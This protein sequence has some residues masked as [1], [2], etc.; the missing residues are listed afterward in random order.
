MS[1]YG[2]G[3]VESDD[4]MVVATHSDICDVGGSAWHDAVVCGGNMR[5]GADKEGSTSVDEMP[6]GIFFCGE[7]CVDIDNDGV[8]VLF[9]EV[10]GEFFIEGIEGTFCAGH[11]G[12][13]AGDLQ[14]EDLF[15]IFSF[16]D[17]DSCTWLVFWVVV[18]S[19]EGSVFVEE[20]DDVGA[21]PGVI[22]EGDEVDSGLDELMEMFL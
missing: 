19:Y 20:V 5:V 1:L 4:G 3:G 7:F 15:S 18:G 9:V 11:H 13:H 6:E 10:L 8:E 17:S 22:S 21:I 14:D 12:D 2:D 16:G